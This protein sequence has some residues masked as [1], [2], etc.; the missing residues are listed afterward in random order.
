MIKYLAK[1]TVQESGFFQFFLDKNGSCLT[2]EDEDGRY[3][4]DGHIPWISAAAE[5][6]RFTAPQSSG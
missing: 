5:M 1:Q 4:Y 3:I 6:G 2:I